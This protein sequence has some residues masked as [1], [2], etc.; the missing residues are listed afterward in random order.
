MIDGYNQSN[1][2][3]ITVIPTAYSWDEMFAKWVLAVSSGN[4]PDVA[5]YHPTETP[6][7]VE[8]DTLI[9]MDDLAAQ[10]GWSWEG[11]PE[12]VKQMSYYDGKLYGILEDFH[13]MAMYYN[14]DLVKAA[15][16]DPDAPPTTQEEF[17]NWATTLTLKDDAGNIS[18]VGAGMPTTGTARWIWH[19]YLYQNKGRFLDDENKAAF[20][21]EEGLGALQFMHDLLHK[22]Q[23]APVGHNDAED[24]RAGKSGIEF[25]GP[26]NVNAWLTAG[27]NIRTAP[28][29][30]CFQQPAAWCNSH[31][32]SLSKSDAPDRQLAGMKFIQWFALNNLEA[33]VNVGIIPV[34]PKVMAELQQHER[35]QYYKAFADEAKYLAYE[36]MVPQYSQIF[37]FGK[38]TPLVVNLEAALTNQKPLQQALDDMEAGINE[39]LATPIS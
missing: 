24:F 14:V 22:Y 32:L 28:L 21:S 18:Q 12:P 26:W 35:W 11:I 33:A 15:G 9:P 23:I 30:N 39:I 4:P 6:E 25:N 7:F 34:T 16:L 31:I 19:S 20:N 3:G 36:P 5:L 8:R 1:T 13:P 38:P 37:S 10:V 2:D 27:L 17:V 29:P